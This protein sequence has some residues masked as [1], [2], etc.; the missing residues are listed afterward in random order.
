LIAEKN[1]FVQF[2]KDMTDFMNALKSTKQ[3]YDQSPMLLLLDPSSGQISEVDMVKLAPTP[4]RVI[5]STSDMMAKSVVSEEQFDK[6]YH[7]TD[8]VDMLSV[9]TELKEYNPISLREQED[10]QAHQAATNIKEIKQLSTSDP[11][12]NVDYDCEI[13]VD[14]L[15]TE[16]IIASTS[17]EY[18]SVEVTDNRPARLAV[19]E[20]SEFTMLEN[21]I[22]LTS[23]VKVDRQ[24]SITSM[25]DVDIPTITLAL[26]ILPVCI[27]KTT[28]SAVDVK[29]VF[30]YIKKNE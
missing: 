16:K 15:H 18:D 3:H 4:D 20:Q 2:K 6:K 1:S 13:N 24:I 17:D 10:S 23:P 29:Y 22:K 30:T 25:I 21:V 27:T 12:N 5:F 11:K 9:S 19:E 26:E 28:S 8:A 14:V 7:D